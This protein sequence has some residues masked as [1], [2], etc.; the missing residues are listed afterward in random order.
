MLIKVDS[1]GTLTYYSHNHQD[2]VVALSN[3]GGTVTN[4]FKY[5][6]WGESPAMS[7][8]T[9]VFTGQRVESAAGLYYM[10]TRYYSPAIELFPQPDPILYETGDLNLYA[11]VKNDPLNW[12]DPM[13]WEPEKKD[14]PKKEP[15]KKEP[16][17]KDPPDTDPPEGDPQLVGPGAKPCFHACKKPPKGRCLLKRTAPGAKQPCSSQR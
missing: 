17:K 3:S 10:K 4:R 8:I 14:P 7:G 2:S 11:Y 1:G 16:I 9:D 12:I 5:S 13:G 15:I 6:P